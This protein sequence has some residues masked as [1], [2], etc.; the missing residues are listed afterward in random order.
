MPD[1]PFLEPERAT[2]LREVRELFGNALGYPP[3][4]IQEIH[5]LEIDLGMD[6]LRKVEMLMLLSRRY[7]IPEPQDMSELS[8]Y[9][10]VG[11]VLDAILESAPE[12]T[13]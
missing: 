6:S 11:S 2:V 5:Y 10:T 13:P 12:F 1:T 7:G 3:E 4:S 9:T 8:R